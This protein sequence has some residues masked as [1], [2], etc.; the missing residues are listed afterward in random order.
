[1]ASGLRA[2]YPGV[3]PA[4][5]LDQLGAG[6]GADGGGLGRQEQARSL[7]QWLHT[8][9]LGIPKSALKI[10]FVGAGA[11]HETYGHRTD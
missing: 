6:Q 7:E 5:V 4:T 2:L 1:M 8:Q 11:E 10:G 3:S 9:G